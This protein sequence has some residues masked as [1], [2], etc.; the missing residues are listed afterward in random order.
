[1]DTQQ[2]WSIHLQKLASWKGVF[3]GWNSTA[4]KPGWVSDTYSAFFKT[5]KNGT[6]GVI[7]T[8]FLLAL[9]KNPELSLNLATS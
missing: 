8:A 7:T 9:T 6:T 2:D 1:M 4:P 3:H 5:P